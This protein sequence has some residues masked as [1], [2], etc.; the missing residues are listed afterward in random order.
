MLLKV[1]F[2]HEQ[3]REKLRSS[4]TALCPRLAGS[5]FFMTSPLPSGFLGPSFLVKLGLLLPHF[6]MHLLSLCPCLGLSQVRVEK[7]RWLAPPLAATAPLMGEEV[8]LHVRFWT[9]QPCRHH[10]ETLSHTR[11]KNLQ[12]PL[13][14]LSTPDTLFQ[15]VGCLIPGW[16]IPEGKWS[17]HYQFSWTS[18]SGL[19]SLCPPATVDFFFF[20]SLQIAAPCLLS[21]VCSCIQWD[22]AYPCLPE[23]ELL[24]TPY[25]EVLLLLSSN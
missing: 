16:G 12:A 4:E 18:S 1:R 14:P 7:K 24:P 8:S 5:S 22:S 15:T 11:R 9:C 19:F 17:T 25:P 20:L 3:F 13:E 2:I 23:L 21:R 10:S 6:A